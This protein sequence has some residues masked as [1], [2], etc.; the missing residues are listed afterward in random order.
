MT[1]MESESSGEEELNIYSLPKGDDDEDDLNGISTNQFAVKAPTLKRKSSSI[2]SSPTRPK[3]PPKKQIKRTPSTRSPKRKNRFDDEDDDV[4]EFED[5]F[6]DDDEE[7]N[8][9]N[10]RRKKSGASPSSFNSSSSN[11]SSYISSSISLDNFGE[12]NGD[13]F[14]VELYDANDEE[15]EDIHFLIGDVTHPNVKSNHII[16]L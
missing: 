16:V 12:E 14:D 4:D 10:L 2:R 3:P 8:V 13:Q 15:D 7:V 6:D 5:D 9:R 11:S 1:V